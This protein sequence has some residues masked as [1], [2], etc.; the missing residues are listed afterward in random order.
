M[1]AQIMS[2]LNITPD[3]FSDGGEF[4]N[5]EKAYEKAQNMIADGADII[6]IGGESSA[7]NSVEVSAEKEWR[8]IFPVLKKVLPC[9]VPVSVDTWKSDIAEKSLR[10]GVNII[11]DIT[12]FRGDSNMV[13]VLKHSPC[14]IVIM[15]SK[16]PSARTTLAEKKYSDVVREV[17]DF[18]EER[19]E[20]AQKNG[21][22]KKR[23][24]L[25]VGM[26]AF[27]SSDPAVS[28]EMLARI[29]EIKA[30]FPEQRILVG[31]SRKGFLR[32]VS[33]AQNPK[34]R[35]IASVVSS[36]IAIQNDADIVRVHD[37][38]EMR[39][40]LDTFLAIREQ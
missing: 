7:P 13:Q 36:L 39:E 38:K 2:V 32:T 17:G 10:M 1:P 40:A 31:T 16:D 3:S 24:I 27:L 18:L 28:F 5:A 35:V 37:T 6:D 33:D 14:D 9:S 21:I 23:I 20:Y 22:E 12:A 26:G 25:D 34:K 29:G 11:N 15:Y 30:R 19:L 4:E 8:R